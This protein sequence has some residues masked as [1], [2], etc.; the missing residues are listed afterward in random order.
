VPALD[1]AH[2]PTAQFDERGMTPLERVFRN[3]EKDV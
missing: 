3:D 2:T 1:P